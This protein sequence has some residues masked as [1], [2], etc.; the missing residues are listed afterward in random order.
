MLKV[1]DEVFGT[2]TGGFAEDDDDIAE[3]DQE[4]AY[5][6]DLS[7]EKKMVP[8][9][10]AIPSKP[11]PL[12]SVALATAATEHA[13]SLSFPGDV[14]SNFGFEGRGRATSLQN[15]YFPSASLPS[16]GEIRAP[17]P[18][19]LSARS[20]F[21]HRDASSDADGTTD[22]VSSWAAEQLL[23]HLNQQR[24]QEQ[25]DTFR[26]SGSV[27]GLG[28]DQTGFSG[29]QHHAQNPYTA[30]L[31]ANIAA[32]QQRANASFASNFELS[33]EEVSFFLWLECCFAASSLIR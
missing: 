32:T 26:Y 10:N 28:P 16:Q 30:S 3:G 2:F 8:V 33:A 15:T 21:L 22:K 25:M 14:Q 18:K 27:S 9:T 13:L 12:A 4:G 1:E 31:L 24:Q 19:S 20:S 5:A 17:I 6:F 7:Q 29:L 23:N 11:I